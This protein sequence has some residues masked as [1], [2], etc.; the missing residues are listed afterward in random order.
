MSVLSLSA[1]SAILLVAGAQAP[2]PAAA[3]PPT[4]TVTG[5]RATDAQVKHFVEAFAVASHSEKL[6]RFESPICP[7][8]LGLE[9]RLNHELERR[10]RRVA[11]AAGL[12]VGKEGCKSNALIFVTADKK[13]LLDSIRKTRP[14]LFGEL[15]PGQISVLAN[16]RDPAI[17]WQVL[18]TRSADGRM[19]AGGGGNDR[20]EALY[21][22]TSSR[23]LPQT[24]VDFGAA[25]VVLEASA[26]ANLTLT[27]IA[28][29]AA[30][31]AF[32]HTDPEAAAKQSAPTILTL[33]ADKQA[34]RPSP[35]SVTEWDLAYLKSLYGISNM[36]QAGAQRGELQQLMRKN[37]SARSAD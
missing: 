1:L 4:I 16:S 24:R 30:M 31:R 22:V 17:V 34:G 19:L 33:I 20:P 29:Y 32:A 15:T 3:D 11:A 36:L 2:A 27:Q 28:D 14:R 18:E 37:L 12:Q 13:A 6:A 9:D 10:M 23:L 7:A 8:A 35:L 21:G 26:I 5:E 25:V